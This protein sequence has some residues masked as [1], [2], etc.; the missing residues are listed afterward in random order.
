MKRK[1]RGGSIRR[2]QPIS[3]YG[4]TCH[5]AFATHR[6]A[7]PP[8]RRAAAYAAADQTFLRVLNKAAGSA[9]TRAA[10]LAYATGLHALVMCVLLARAHGG[11][12][13]VRAGGGRRRG[14]RGRWGGRPAHVGGA[15]KERGIELVIAGLAGGRV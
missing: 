13:R 10:A 14:G 5:Q 4:T 12:G 7:K 1:R 6:A 11:G 9:G 3:R 2:C 15:V 8:G